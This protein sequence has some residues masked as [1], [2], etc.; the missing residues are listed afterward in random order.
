[1]ENYF[2]ERMRAIVASIDGYEYVWA[3]DVDGTVISDSMVP[4]VLHFCGAALKSEWDHLRFV[5]KSL[6][7]AQHLAICVESMFAR[8]G[9]LAE[10]LLFGKNNGRLMPGFAEFRQALERQSVCIVGFTNNATQ[11]VEPILEHLGSH[12]PLLGNMLDETGKFHTVHGEIGL[13]KGEGIRWLHKHGFKIVGYAGDGIGDIEAAL[14][15]LSLSG[16]VVALGENEDGFASD[17]HSLAHHVVKD[18][19]TI[20]SHIPRFVEQCRTSWLA[21]P[22]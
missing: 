18:Y 19:R 13:D 7:T 20:E 10:M 21:R 4:A 11:I 6:T 5:E 3:T 14:A 12:F 8:A 9:S 17:F 15:T 2:E 16:T 1:M 22:S